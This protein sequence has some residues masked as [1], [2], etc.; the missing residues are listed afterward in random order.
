MK[1]LERENDFGEHVLVLTYHPAFNCI[2]EILR[3][4]HVYKSARL[5]I[6]LKSPSQVAFR[7]AKTLKDRLV[8]SKLRNES[9]IETGTFK[10]NSK[11]CEVC[12]YIEPGSKFKIFVTQKSYKIIFR[13]D[14]NSSHVIYLISCKIRGHQYTGTTVA[15]FRER[16]N[17]YK[18]NVNLYSQEVRGMMQ[19]KMIS[20]FFIEN[21]NRCSKDVS[22]QIIDHCDP[23]DKE[24]RE[25]YWIETL[26]TSYQ[27]G[28]N[29]K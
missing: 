25:T 8:R 17:Q 26:E 27:K 12:N 9:E 20:H 4:A 14:C 13:F 10:G 28:L 23:N 16:F 6:I 3:N 15:H 19:E 24:Q 21:H 7:S 11:R 18:S 1:K 2:H 22:V 29:Y 5:A